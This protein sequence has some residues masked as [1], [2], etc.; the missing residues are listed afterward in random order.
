[1]DTQDSAKPLCEFHVKIYEN[2]AIIDPPTGTH[3]ITVIW[4]H[5]MT[6]K[7]ADSIKFFSQGSTLSIPVVFDFFK[8]FIHTQCYRA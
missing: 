2:E 6:M 1:M 3:Q 8:S 5:G 7:A 4:L